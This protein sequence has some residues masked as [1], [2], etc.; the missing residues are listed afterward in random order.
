MVCVC[1]QVKGFFMLLEV[2]KRVICKNVQDIV[3]KRHQ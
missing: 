3:T 1:Q 2:C